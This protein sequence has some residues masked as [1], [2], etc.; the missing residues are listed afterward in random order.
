[1]NKPIKSAI[2]SIRSAL[3]VIRH[4]DIRIESLER[5]IAH[6]DQQ[7]KNLIAQTDIEKQKKESLTYESKRL[8]EEIK[9]THTEKRYYIDDL[10]HKVDTYDQYLN[11]IY[12]NTDFS[13]ISD[14][15]NKYIQSPITRL[16]C[17]VCEELEHLDNMTDNLNIQ[18]TDNINQWLEDQEYEQEKTKE[19]KSQS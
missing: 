16:R 17:H 15:L 11:M 4:Y 12:P 1:M 6:V 9:Q 14:L 18:F 7:R 19:A 8:A 5:A 10:K 13:E 3:N 2:R